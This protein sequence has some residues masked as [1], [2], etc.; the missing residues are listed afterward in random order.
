VT[1]ERLRILHV[2]P[3]SRGGIGKHVAQVASALGLRDDTSVGVGRPPESVLGTVVHPGVAML[4]VR[5]PEGLSAGHLQGALDIRRLVR[6]HDY[7]VVHAHGLR[8]SLDAAIG[9]AGLGIPMVMTVHNLIRREIVGRRRASLY[10]RAE[11]LAVRRATRTLAA[12]RQ[13]ADHLSAFAPKGREIEVL[14]VPAPPPQVTRN[15]TLTRADLGVDDV[16]PLIVTA[17]RLAPQ[18]ALDVMLEA[19]SFLDK[20]H[21]VVIGEGPLRTVLENRAGVLGISE[22]VRFLGFRDDVGNILAAAD[23]FCLSS[24][25]EAVAL[26]AQ[27]AVLLEVPV[28]STNAGGMNELIEDGVSGRLVPVGDAKALAVAL[29][30][31]LE[32]GTGTAY[33]ARALAAYRERFSPDATVNRLIEIYRELAGE[34]S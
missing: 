19:V 25:W 11:R 22:R 13:I 26:A 15:R 6:A 31:V 32:E 29:E 21:L 7:Q 33:A 8:A 34:Q 20:A 17:A 23:A 1:T 4:E 3:R 28:V 18:K 30:E 24:V 2:L 12:S 27:E 10:R 14:Y 16:A 9:V 5:I